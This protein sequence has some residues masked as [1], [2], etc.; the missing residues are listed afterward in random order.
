VPEI[1]DHLTH[2]GRREVHQY[3]AAEDQIHRVGVGLERRINVLHQ[4]QR[5]KRH[6]LLDLRDDGVAAIRDSGKIA[7]LEHRWRSAE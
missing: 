5:G 4:I 7:L 6:Q 1:P 3:I 2:L